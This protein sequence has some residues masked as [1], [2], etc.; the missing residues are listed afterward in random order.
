MQRQHEAKP[1][2]LTEAG[3]PVKVAIT[4]AMRKLV[5]LAL[6]EERLW[7]PKPIDQDGYSGSF[8][9]GLPR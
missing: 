7:T 6:R 5:I 4:A 1:E 9:A 8:F 3:K 2:T